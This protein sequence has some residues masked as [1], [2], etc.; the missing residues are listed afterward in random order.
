MQHNIGY[1]SQVDNYSWWNIFPGW[2]QCF[3]T[4][5]WM[6]MSFFSAKI[7][8]KNDT[9]LAQYVD[10]VEDTVG[11]PGIGELIKRKYNWVKGATSLWWL[12]QEA[13]ITKW[14]NSFG[15]SG[16]AKF[17]NGGSYVD[18]AL[19]LEKGPV[20]IGTYKLKGLSGGHII[21]LVG[22]DGTNFIV[23][24]P[25]GD[26]NSWYKDKDGLAKKYPVALITSVCGIKPLYI[27]WEI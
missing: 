4:S 18:I 19:K 21:L 5:A 9:Q 7:E 10:D 26:A 20:I 11:K 17:T 2:T 27:S 13:G 22:F 1:N 16:H 6:F 14:L 24:D 3:S 25:Y 23:N 15:V 12:V 8:V